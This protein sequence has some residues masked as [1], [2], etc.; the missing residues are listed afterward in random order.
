[1]SPAIINEWQDSARLVAGLVEQL[2]TS[3]N[4]PCL[5][6]SSFVPQAVPERSFAQPS[7]VKI[8]LLS[9]MRPPLT[10][11]QHPPPG[12]DSGIVLASKVFTSSKNWGGLFIIFTQPF[13][14]SDMGPLGQEC[15]LRRE[16]R[17]WSKSEL[18]E[19]RK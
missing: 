19:T 10:S 15:S 16:G 1:M 12:A 3:L 4:L 13:Q 2:T 11:P 8:E 7:S 5:S 9:Q 14:S 18:C 6:S 17:T